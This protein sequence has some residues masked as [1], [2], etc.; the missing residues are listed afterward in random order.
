M[1]YIQNQGIS[2]TII[3]NN[4]HKDMYQM[5]WDADYDGHNA[6]ISVNLLDKN[7]LR[8]YEAQLDNTD[9]EQL[10]SVPSINS[11]LHRRLMKDFPRKSRKSCYRELPVIQLNSHENMFPSLYVPNISDTKVKHRCNKS[12]KR[13][14]KRSHKHYTHKSY[15]HY[16]HLSSPA[17]NEQ[18]MLLPSHNRT[19]SRK[20]KTF[21]VKTKHYTI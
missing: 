17:K 15:K 12:H 2:Q 1:S 19:S 20:K 13:S 21:H 4:H 14:H 11:P 7:K 16:T 5:N 8:H 18:L 6:N 9:L 3:R 10:F